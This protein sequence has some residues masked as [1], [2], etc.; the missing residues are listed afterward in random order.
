MP[1]SSKAIANIHLL[2]LMCNE[3]LCISSLKMKVEFHMIFTCHKILLFSPRSGVGLASGCSLLTLTL[4]GK[5]E[6]NIFIL[7]LTS[8]PKSYIS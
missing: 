8:A 2:M 4:E 5:T 6:E 7:A 1:L 3:I